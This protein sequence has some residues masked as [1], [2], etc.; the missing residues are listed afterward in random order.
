MWRNESPC[1][2]WESKMALTLWKIV[3]YFL[4]NLNIGLSR[5]P[6]ISLLGIYPIE[7]KAGVQTDI[8][9]PVFI[10]ALFTMAK[11]RKQP[12]VHCW[13]SG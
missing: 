4:Q 12:S 11:K 13:M 10:T 5:G 7:V 9:T 8:Y 2:W 3:W 6:V 1:A